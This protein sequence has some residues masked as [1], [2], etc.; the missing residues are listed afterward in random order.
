[1][2]GITWAMK[3]THGCLGFLLGGFSYAASLD[4]D[5]A[6]PR[7]GWGCASIGGFA[8]QRV[9]DATLHPTATWWRCVGKCPDWE[10]MDVGGGGDSGGWVIFGDLNSYPHLSICT[11]LPLIGGLIGTYCQ[12]HSG[13]VANHDASSSSCWEWKLDELDWGLRVFT[14]GSCS[15][16]T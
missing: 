15:V 10:T 13:L 2:G 14:L 5:G 6:A 16:H 7:L 1:M 4:G 12:L 9:A 3:K 8:P 11:R